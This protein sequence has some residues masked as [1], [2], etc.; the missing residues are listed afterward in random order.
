MVEY[1]H[2][3]IIEKSFKILRE[4]QKKYQFILIGGWAVFFYTKSLKSKDVDIIVEFEELGKLKEEFEVFKNNRLRKY[5]IKKEGVDIDIYVP[6]YSNPGLPPEEIKNYLSSREGFEVPRPELL[7]ILKQKA[8]QERKDSPKGEKDK[9]DIFAL[10]NLVSLDWNLY[11]K[12][13][14]KHHQENFLKDLIQLLRT[15]SE[16]PELNLGP[17]KLSK[18]KKETLLRLTSL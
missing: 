15:T 5:E 11:K 3:L 8:H 10:L 9:I 6:F 7:L 4:F 1:W 17:P 12:I 16:V 18:L 13:L 14:K 2:N